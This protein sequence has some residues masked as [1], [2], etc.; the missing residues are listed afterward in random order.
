MTIDIKKE[1]KH[2]IPIFQQASESGLNEADT[3]LRIGKFIEEGLG[4]DMI[5]D[6]SKEFIIKDR[7]VDYALKINNKPVFFIEVKQG[8]IELKAK[9]IEQAQNYAANAGVKWVI[10]TNGTC[11][12]L[13]H[14]TFE[15]GIQNDL[16]FSVDILK[17]ELDEA[18]A[19]LSLLHKKNVVKGE[20]D[21]YFDKIK[22]LEPKNIMGA[23]LHEKTL[24]LIRHQLKLMTGIR[25]E[26]DE[27]VNNI[28]GMLS[29]ETWERIGDIKIK[30]TKRHL[31][32]KKEDE[33]NS[34]RVTP[35]EE[36]AKSS[37]NNEPPSSEN[38]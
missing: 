25:V 3:S 23:I 5:T 21:N 9:H 13:Y 24:K 33:L 30:R 19:K 14:L 15:D 31:R 16:V 17:E 4:Y 18:A 27:L 6:V 2:F 20:F 10:L 28:K 8:G 29:P 12:H 11:W 35:G 22:A 7:Y 36:D 32:I 38:D 37:K 1:L 26:E 34:N